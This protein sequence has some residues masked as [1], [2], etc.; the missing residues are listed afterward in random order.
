MY[1]KLSERLSNNP[2]YLQ[3]LK[4]MTLKEKVQTLVDILTSEEDLSKPLEKNFLLNFKDILAT[5]KYVNKPESKSYLSQRMRKKIESTDI[6]KM[7]VNDFNKYLV[8]KTV[9]LIQE[10][11]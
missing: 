4:S 3:D 9:E 6:P 11:N 8:D 7:N 10:K 1:I 5:L 2:N